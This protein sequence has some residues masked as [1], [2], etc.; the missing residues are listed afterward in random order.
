MHR[1]LVST[2]ARMQSEQ[3][4]LTLPRIVPLG[5]VGGGEYEAA[6]QGFEVVS[7]EWLDGEPMPIAHVRMKP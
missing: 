6:M 1:E 7:S 2:N 3:D 5:T 4:A